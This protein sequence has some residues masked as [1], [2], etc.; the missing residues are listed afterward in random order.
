LTVT[1]QTLIMPAEWTMP[2][3][4]MRRKKERTGNGK[5]ICCRVS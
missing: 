5:Y 2:S 4:I 1:I 3:M